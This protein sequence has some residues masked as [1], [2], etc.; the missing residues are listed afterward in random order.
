MVTIRSP[1]VY[2]Q[3]LPLLAFLDQLVSQSSDLRS[4]PRKFALELPKL[5]LVAFG[6]IRESR[7]L[8][9]RG[10]KGLASG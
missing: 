10:R 2:L 7:D 6:R 8:I 9:R 1:Q 5:D 3:L 4:R